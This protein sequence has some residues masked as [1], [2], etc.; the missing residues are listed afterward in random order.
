MKNI[1]IY[2]G[3]WG[4]EFLN[5]CISKINGMRIKA[6][7]YSKKF[8]TKNIV[9][10]ENKKT[11]V[12][13]NSSSKVVVKCHE[14]DEFN[15]KIGLGLAISKMINS[16]KHRAMREFFRNKKKKLD[17]KKYAEWVLLDYC[18]YNPKDVGA[19]ILLVMINNTNTKEKK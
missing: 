12:I 2:E 7:E 18:N 13:Y 5:L 19:F 3:S 16:K 8:S 15:I 17:Y 10:N 14:D 11:V 4:Y 1:K 6:A 9:V